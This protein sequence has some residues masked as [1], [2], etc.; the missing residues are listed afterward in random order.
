MKNFLLVGLG[1]P[2]K[3]YSNNRHNIGF[4]LIDYYLNDLNISGFK[5]K[6]ESQYLSFEHMN[7]KIHILK[8]ETYMN[9]SGKAVKE[10]SNFYK[11]PI[12]NIISIYDEMDLQVGE[13]KI[14][15]G[16]GSAGHNG[17]KSL[18]N[19]LSSEDFIRVRI[20]IGKP[21]NKNLVNKHV[22]SDFTPDELKSLD[23]IK[24]NISS[25]IEDL[26]INGLSFAMNKFNSKIQ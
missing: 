7:N 17:I 13:M 9:E 8:P 3:K 26:I 24:N 1:N 4:Q 21:I 6:F 22:L 12:S 18:I 23:A 10:C 2:G 5:S 25:V 19:N 14:K 11:I 15:H 20:G 16:G